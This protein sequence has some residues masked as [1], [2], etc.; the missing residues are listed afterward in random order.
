MR[1]FRVGIRSHFYQNP[2]VLR[3]DLLRF[4]V[5]ARHAEKK[6]LENVLDFVKNSF[7]VTSLDSTGAQAI[8]K[9]RK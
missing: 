9:K 3:A 1:G 6:K 2:V 8:L 5:V 7:L 4:A